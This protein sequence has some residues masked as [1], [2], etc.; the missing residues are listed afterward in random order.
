NAIRFGFAAPTFEAPQ[1]TRYSTMLDGFDDEWSG[2][3]PDSRRDYTNIPG[4]DYTFRV[5]AINIFK[6]ES[7]E[8]QC[9]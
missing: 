8:E 2:W 6:H 1:A 4:G 3:S 5:K 7:T 9:V